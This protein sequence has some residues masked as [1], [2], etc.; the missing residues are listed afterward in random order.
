MVLRGERESTEII[1][2]LLQLERGLTGQR[3]STLSS[4]VIG[5]IPRGS[6]TFSKPKKQ[7]K[8]VPEELRS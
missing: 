2:D 6:T 8:K 4:R 7:K 1:G 3:R 5:R